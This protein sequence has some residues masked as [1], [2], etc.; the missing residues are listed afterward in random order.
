MKE[1]EAVHCNYPVNNQQ[2]NVNS[3]SQNFKEDKFAPG[4]TQKKRN[5]E[6]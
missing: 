1:S 4:A 5:R 6:L 2:R 3:M